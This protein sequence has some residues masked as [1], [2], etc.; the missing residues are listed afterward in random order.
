MKKT[1]IV[2]GTAL[3]LFANFVTASNQKLTIKN[4]NEISIYL[5]S[6]YFLY[7]QRPWAR[8]KYKNLKL[9]MSSIY[10]RIKSGELLARITEV[11]LIHIQKLLTPTTSVVP[12]KPEKE[13]SVF[14]IL[15]RK[16]LAF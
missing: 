6:L 3:F 11:L 8:K 1:V 13:Q 12:Q 10:L 4:Q 5:S 7:L 15:M 9:V 2:L 16:A 14:A